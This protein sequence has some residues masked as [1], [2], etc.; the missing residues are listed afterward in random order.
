MTA[1]RQARWERQVFG[2]SGGATAALAQAALEGLQTNVMIADP[3]LNIIYMNTSVMKLMREAEAELKRELPRFSVATLIGSNID[4]FHK[5]PSHQRRMLATLS[6]QHAA[7]I[8]IGARPFDLLVTPLT[9]DGKRAG[10]AVEWS[11][12]RA[13]LLNVDYAC[14]IEAI[15]RSQAVIELGTDGTI[16][17]ANQNFLRLVG[18][19]LTELQGRNH[20]TLVD[21]AYRQSAEY[22]QFWERLRR[23]EFQAGQFRRIAKDGHEVWIEGAYNPILDSNGR[24]VKIVKFATDITAQV[25]LLGNLKTLIDRNFGEIDGAISRSESEAQSAAQAASET[26]GNVHAVSENAGQL[27]ASIGEIAQSMAKSRSATEDAFN[28]ATAVGRNTE[29][30]AGAAQAMSG[31]VGLIRSVA[32]QINM[33]ALNATIEAARAGEAGRG[34]A[35]VASEV[36]NLA[37]QAARATEQ[38][39]GEIDGIQTTSAQVAGA[40]GAIRDAVTSVRESVAVTAAAVEEQSAVTRT[41]S[42]NMQ[43]ASGAVATITASINEITMAVQQAAGAVGKTKQA[44]QVLVR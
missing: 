16:I 14:Q 11:D 12:A 44:A 8:Q 36:K 29:A 3:N 20:S 40:L 26:S 32:S 31:I 28:Q 10:F 1:L 35:V 37:V 2:K 18:Y 13:R 33:L 22:Q 19:S 4:V 43:S 17:S 38:I 7:T 21:A 23:G 41:M 27:A 6:R 30:L 24:V 5:D 39:S 25:G 42:T 34:F 15:S 9:I